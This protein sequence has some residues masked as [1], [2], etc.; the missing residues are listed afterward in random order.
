M[1]K[2]YHGTNGNSSNTEQFIEKSIAVH[3]VGTFDYSKVVYKHSKL[4]VDIGCLKCGHW[5]KQKPNHNLNSRGCPVCANSKRG[6]NR[7]TQEV[8]LSR[9]AETH[10][11]TYD[12]SLSEYAQ[13][14]K[15]VCIICRKHGQFWQAPKEHY[16]GAGCPECFEETRGQAKQVRAADSFISDSVL[17]HGDKYDYSK[18]EYTYSD[19]YVVIGCKRCG[20]DFKQTPA[21]HKSG[22]GCTTCA[23]DARGF[24]L[25][26]STEDF[27][28]NSI[29]KHGI[30]KFTYDRTVYTKV[31]DRVEI[32]CNSCGNYWSTLPSKHLEGHGC[33]YCAEYGFSLDKSAVLYVLEHEDIIKIGIT[34][35]KPIKRVK[36][37]NKDSGYMFSIIKTYEFDKGKDCLAAE[38]SILKL[39][40]NSYSNPTHRYSGS[41]EC[42]VGVDKANLFTV[43]NEVLH[44]M[45]EVVI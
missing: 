45:S 44:G 31:H 25:R 19:E 9:C 30:G 38:T 17:L 16:S 42:F 27:V 39:L 32:G 29:K 5:F 36:E 12:Y 13:C 3:G 37:I 2:E 20:T 6:G 15:K 21:G 24:A 10:G 41:T 34:N 7:L 23:A 40:R 8:F 26:N 1:S 14:E 28:A 4:H 11:D 43:V 33:P 18:V 35:R 22:Y